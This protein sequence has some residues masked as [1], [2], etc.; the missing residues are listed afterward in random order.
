MEDLEDEN[1]FRRAQGDQLFTEK[2]KG[3]NKSSQ[4]PFFDFQCSNWPL[5]NFA[6][7]GSRRLVLVTHVP[8]DEDDVFLSKFPQHHKQRHFISFHASDVFLS[9]SSV[10]LSGHPTDCLPKGPAKSTTA[11]LLPNNHLSNKL[12]QLLNFV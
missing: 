9:L 7:R 1:S 6:S 12:P 3:D 2:F 4:F 8:R 11:F 10:G 5:I